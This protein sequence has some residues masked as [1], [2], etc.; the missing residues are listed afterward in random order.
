MTL[1]R[2]AMVADYQNKYDTMT[3][4]RTAAVEAEARRIVAGWDRYKVVEQRTGVPA[5]FIGAIHS[6]EC[7][8]DFNGCLANGQSYRRRT[9]IVPVGA[10][11]W[12]TWEDSA[13]WALKHEGFI[14]QTAWSMGD[15]LFDA[16]VLNGEGYHNHGY[17]NPYLWGGT[18]YYH[19][20]KYVRDRVYNGNF[21]DPQ[22][23]VAPVIKRVLELTHATIPAK[24]WVPPAPV[25]DNGKLHPEDKKAVVQ[26]SRFLRW[27]QLYRNA[28]HAVTVS[29]GT[30]FEGFEKAHP[31]LTDWR[32]IT[33]LGVL[34][35]GYLAVWAG[36]VNLLGAIKAGRY[37]PSGFALTDNGVTPAADPPT[38]E[39]APEA[40]AQEAA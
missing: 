16:E 1:N 28:C 3:V 34:G 14:G 31:Y 25:N 19:K 26:N 7:D 38:E 10:G 22:C 21:V 29:W 32:T 33:V 4:S 37:T 27:G 15:M 24:P 36:Q 23:G 9:T 12:A 2:S 30:I 13:V 35:G 5:I 18:Q 6:R 40:Q 17:E 20:G 11:P 8:N 39:T